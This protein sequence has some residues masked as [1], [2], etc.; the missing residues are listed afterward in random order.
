[1]SKSRRRQFPIFLTLSLSA[2]FLLWLLLFLSPSDRPYH[3][4]KQ[5]EVEFVPIEDLPVD[6][7]KQIVT[8]EKQLNDEIDEKAKFLSAFNQKVQKETRIDRAG[9]FNNAAKAGPKVEQQAAREPQPEPENKP[10]PETNHEPTPVGPQNL[11]SLSSLK[12]DFTP[13]P[14]APR[15]AG[16]NGQNEA[17]SATDDYLQDVNKGMETM[18]ST[19][20]FVYYSYYNRIKERIRQ[21][22]EPTIREK[23]KMIFRQGRTI[24]STKDHI[25]QVMITLNNQGELENV[26]VV[27]PSGLEQLDDAAVDAFRDAQPFPNPPKG[28]VES[29][30]KIRIRWDFVLEASTY[31]PRKIRRSFAKGN[32]NESPPPRRI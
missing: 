16:D 3:P 11:P 27:T 25:T 21:H 32:D 26:E 4:E 2:H 31:Q 23:V 29:D 17:P 8:Q 14:V 18:L 28:M 30:G 6:I 5:V 13:H 12:P 20:E 22:W 9:E 15:V 24:A 10:K 19:R 7:Q 1:M